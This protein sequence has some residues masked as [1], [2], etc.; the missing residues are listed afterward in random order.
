MAGRF[1]L[2]VLRMAELTAKGGIDLGVAN[3]AVCHLWQIGLARG[4][5]LF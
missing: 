3:Q 5:R 4:V 1:D 2:R